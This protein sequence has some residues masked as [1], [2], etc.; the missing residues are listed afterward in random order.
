MNRH[1]WTS[2]P[3][4]SRSPNIRCMVNWWRETRISSSVL[5]PRI[6]FRIRL[7]IFRMM[8]SNSMSGWST[9]IT[10]RG[11]N[12][13]G[14]PPGNTLHP[15]SGPYSE[16]IRSTS[17]SSKGRGSS[18]CTS[19][20]WVWPQLGHGSVGRWWSDVIFSPCH[21]A[22]CSAQYPLNTNIPSH[23]CRLLIKN[24]VELT[25]QRNPDRISD[26]D[27]LWPPSLPTVD[28]AHI[29]RR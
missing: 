1:C 2:M 11:L 13:P 17:A 3:N 14:T 24:G 16:A 20:V 4:F 7:R 6:C 21:N 25:I 12:G 23:G 19:Q 22:P 28:V 5:I 10:S 29:G 26:Q 9:K 27:D 15:P 8:S 18:Q